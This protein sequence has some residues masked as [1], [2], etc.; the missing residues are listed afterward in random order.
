MA[1]VQTHAAA[2]AGPRRGEGAPL[3]RPSPA[4][5]CAKQVPGSMGIDIPQRGSA[6]PGSPREAAQSPRTIKVMLHIAACRLAQI[7]VDS[8]R[9]SATQKAP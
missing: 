9:E 4:A 8:L 1:P 5:G 2:E 3:G 6:V 7:V